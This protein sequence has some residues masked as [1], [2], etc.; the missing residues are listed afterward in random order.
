MLDHYTLKNILVFD[1]ETASGEKSYND[2]SESMKMAWKHKHSLIK[3]EI[4]LEASYEKFAALYPEFGRVVCISCGVTLSMKD[5]DG[6]PRNKVITVKSFYGDDEV[7]ILTDFAKTITEFDTKN[8][9]TYLCGHNINKFDIP[10]LAKRMVINRLPIHKKLSFVGLPPWKIDWCIDTMD[11]WKMGNFQGAESIKVLAPVFGIETPKDDIDGSMVSNVFWN[12][13]GG[14]VRI[15]VYCVKDVIATT[16]ILLAMRN[17][18]IE[19]EHNIV[20]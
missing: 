1:I 18:S 5:D 19:L 14:D 12:E 13:K 15:K 10:F 9:S 7:K 4:S 20:N 3:E 17:E 16:K 11:A 6:K 2:L 8:R